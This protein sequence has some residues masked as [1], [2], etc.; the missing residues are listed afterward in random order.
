MEEVKSIDELY[1][2][3]FG[4]NEQIRNERLQEMMNAL[5]SVIESEGLQV[6][7]SR[8]ELTEGKVLIH[9]R[10]KTLERLK[11]KMARIGYKFDDNYDGW[12]LEVVVYDSNDEARVIE[13]IQD[14]FE[15]IPD[16]SDL[17][18]SDGSRLPMT[19]VG[20]SQSGYQATIILKKGP[21]GITSVR[22]INK[23]VYDRTQDIGDP[24][25]H[26]KYV[27]RQA[28]STDSME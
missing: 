17:T 23:N 25:H 8:G 12:G 14:N 26:D 15:E 18:R 11:A 19:L 16:S 13:A 22:V 27:E 24:L 1:E 28:E 6:V 7:V 4:I 21:Y 9:G 3:K 5:E 20:N 10:V 2:T